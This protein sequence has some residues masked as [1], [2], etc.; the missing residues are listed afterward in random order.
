MAVQCTYCKFGL[1]VLLLLEN[2]KN[3]V[4]CMLLIVCPVLTL[5][6]SYEH[7]KR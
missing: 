6:S 3:I 4:E 2:Y 5:N 1:I 7:Q